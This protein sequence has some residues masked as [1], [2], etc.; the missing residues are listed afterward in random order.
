M[1]HAHQTARRLAMAQQAALV[2]GG[3]SAWQMEEFVRCGEL[4]GSDN[5]DAPGDVRVPFDPDMMKA[6][7]ERAYG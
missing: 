2:W 4:S 6:A 3:M 5:R 7:I 1:Y